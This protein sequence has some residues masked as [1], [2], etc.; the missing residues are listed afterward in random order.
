MRTLQS[1]GRAVAV[2]LIAAAT[3][4]SLRSILAASPSN[5]DAGRS[6]EGEPGFESDRWLYAAPT[7]RDSIGRI[8]APV[9]INGQGPFRFVVDTG[10]THCAVSESLASRLRLPRSTE[11]TILL[12]GVTGSASV[13]SVQVDR[14]ETGELR[15]DGRQMAVIDAMLSGADGVLGAEALEGNRIV[16]DFIRNRIEISA[17]GSRYVRRGLVSVPVTFGLNR[18]LLADAYIGAIKVKAIIDTGAER[19]LGNKV[20]RDKLRIH[21]SYFYAPTM[22]GVQ[23]VTAQIQN[24]EFVTTPSI[25]LGSLQLAHVGVT[26]GD[27]HVF[28]I[29]GLLQE[30]A[31]LI[32]MDV[33]GVL[34]TLVID[35]GNE[36]VQ[37]R[38]RGTMVTTGSRLIRR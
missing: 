28:E 2:A 1:R 29:W 36:Q 38:P 13:A 23:G 16:V 5:T 24:G 4:L 34:D 27:M 3:L 22:T 7:Q 19:T 25:R 14:L 20:L 31:L 37:L 33:L 10:A 17:S 30:P 35:Y 12:S 18:L 9:K 6:V 11:K 26:F 32:G 21:D 8:V 15:H